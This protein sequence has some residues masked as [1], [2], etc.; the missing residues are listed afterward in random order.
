MYKTDQIELKHTTGRLILEADK[1]K[2]MGECIQEAMR[3]A[4]E[5][6]MVVVLIHN[7]RM[8]IIDPNE[9]MQTIVG[10]SKQKNIMGTYNIQVTG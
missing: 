1:G 10:N 3:I 4:I 9:V 7:T 2:G 8:Y 5:K 6:W